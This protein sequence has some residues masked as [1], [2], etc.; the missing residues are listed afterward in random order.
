MRAYVVFTRIRTWDP[1]NSLKILRRRP[2]SWRGTLWS[3][4][5]ILEHTRCWKGSEGKVSA[6]DRGTTLSANLKP[7]QRDNGFRDVANLHQRAEHSRHRT[8]LKQRFV[9]SVVAYGSLPGHQVAIFCDLLRH[10]TMQ[11]RLGS[12][13]PF[14]N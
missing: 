14:D 1:R 8:K 5:P 7:P 12:V 9:V 13:M 2:R 10:C 4:P 3:G 11:L 6:T